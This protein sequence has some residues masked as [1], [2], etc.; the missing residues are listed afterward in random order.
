MHV[1]VASAPAKLRLSP[2]PK[3]LSIRCGNATLP[4]LTHKTASGAAWMTVMSIGTKLVLLI[5]NVA[6]AHLLVP[7]DWGLYA[8]AGVILMLV[9]LLQ[10]AGLRQV[11]IRRQAR[12]SLWAP[13]ALSMAITLGLVAWTVMIGL[14]PIASAVFREPRLTWMIIAIS[15]C[16]PLSA[17]ML[18]PSAKLQ[19]DM[20]FRTMS[21]IEIW[22]PLI[23]MTTSIV[24]ALLGF[25]PWSFIVPQPIVAVIRLVAIWRA[26]G[27]KLPFRFNM[28]RWKPLFGDSAKLFGASIAMQLVEMGDMLVLAATQISAIVGQYKLAVLLSV[29]VVYLLGLSL[30]WVLLPALAQLQGDPERQLNAFRR[31]A[32]IL[33]VVG[34]PLC[35]LQAAAAEP[36]IHVVFQAKWQAAIL[37][38][39]ILSLG[40]AFRMIWP[41]SRS[42]MQAQG[43]F[44]TYLVLSCVYA[45]VYFVAV[46]AATTQGSDSDA[47]RNVAIAVT[48]VFC[49]VCPLDLY[50]AVKPVGGS[51]MDVLRVF[52]LPLVVSAIAVGAAWWL[53]QR[54]PPM[55]GR[56]WVQLLVLGVVSVALYIP[57]IKIVAADA[58]NELIKSLRG[59]IGRPEM[60]VSG[61]T[62]GV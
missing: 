36:A 17:I 56:E 2:A 37:P 44:R 40:M 23:Q 18:V 34:F 4:S 42:L 1:P 46:A 27:L 43:R 31:A 62:P 58:W 11:L 19:I 25:G 50:V 26:A 49:V 38:T 16:A 52:L 41:A 13:V 15:P 20:R 59:L 10:E 7:D 29:Q 39:Q 32:R 47:A 53:A 21:I 54:V 61:T 12:F 48:I 55:A 14:A 30:S 51:F 45:I 9:M 5:G 28:H 3:L 22:M 57:I 6:L 33:A 24:L 60:V 35:L 8:Q